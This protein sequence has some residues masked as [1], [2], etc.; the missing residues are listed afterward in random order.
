MARRSARNQDGAHDEY[1]GLRNEY[2]YLF[3][4]TA[5]SRSAFLEWF[6]M[7]NYYHVLL[8]TLDSL[9]SSWWSTTASSDVPIC[10]HVWC[11][12]WEGTTSLKLIPEKECWMRFSLDIA[13]HPMSLQWRG[14]YG[15]KPGGDIIILSIRGIKANWMSDENLLNSHF[16][17]VTRVSWKR[18]YKIAYE[19]FRILGQETGTFMFVPT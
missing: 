6:Y 16:W 4:S 3:S 11:K 1:F 9:H 2:M 8:I 5:W 12:V 18:D 13:K 15:F 10:E 19:R 7:K 17:L 14:S